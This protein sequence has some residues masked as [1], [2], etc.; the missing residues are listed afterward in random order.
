MAHESNYSMLNL[1]ACLLFLALTTSAFRASDILIA[2]PHRTSG[3]GMQDKCAHKN[4]DVVKVGMRNSMS[5]VSKA[6]YI[7]RAR[8][9]MES[10]T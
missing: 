5:S 3:K 2:S 6:D 7:Y 10:K 8:I 4:V 1:L 9:A